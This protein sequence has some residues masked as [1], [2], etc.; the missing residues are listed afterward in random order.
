[1]YTKECISIIK[2]NIFFYIGFIGICAII[3]T[4]SID[5]T[6]KLGLFI[7]LILALIFFNMIIDLI[8]CCIP[9]TTLSSV[10]NGIGNDILPMYTLR[11]SDDSPIYKTE[12]ITSSYDI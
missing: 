12:S 6:F 2:T 7:L 1:M 3:F 9:D 4:R 8:L 5:I 11:S 10:D